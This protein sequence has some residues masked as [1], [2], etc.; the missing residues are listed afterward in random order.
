MER[1][2]SLLEKRLVEETVKE[3][4]DQINRKINKINRI[5]QGPIDLEKI[6][7]FDK[8]FDEN[9]KATKT[10][11]KAEKRNIKEVKGRDFEEGIY[12]GEMRNNEHKHGKGI[13]YFDK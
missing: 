10:F 9:F 8:N 12:D 7:N 6:I 3:W 1:Q 11:P 13:L 4:E 5:R 2:N